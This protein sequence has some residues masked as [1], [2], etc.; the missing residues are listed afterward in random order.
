MLQVG[1][2]LGMSVVSL[3]VVTWLSLIPHTDGTRLS[4]WGRN[5]AVC[6]ASSLFNVVIFFSPFAALL[7]IFDFFIRFS[8]CFH[9][10]LLSAPCSST[11][12]IRVVYAIKEICH[13][14]AFYF[15]LHQVFP[16]FGLMPDATSLPVSQLH[17]LSL[18]EGSIG[19]LNSPQRFYS[20]IGS[21]WEPGRRCDRCWSGKWRS[22]AGPLSLCHQFPFV[23][24][25]NS[26]FIIY[27]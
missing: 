14:V 22:K 19:L 26:L 21:A 10:F 3:Y 23:L 24:F 17:A 13:V 9:H 4:Q 6:A 27:S 16:S 8:S 2:T 1:L 11:H 25:L 18:S 15:V 7:S 20:Y 5:C 12:Q